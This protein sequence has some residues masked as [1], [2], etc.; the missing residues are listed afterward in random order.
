MKTTALAFEKGS[1]N[2]KKIMYWRNM[3][4]TIFIAVIIIV[5]ILLIVLMFYN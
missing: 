5:F 1:D 4:L 3:K 2:L